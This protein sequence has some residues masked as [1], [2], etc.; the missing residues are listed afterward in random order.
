[1]YQHR[2]CLPPNAGLG[3]S[4]GDG[5]LHRL[6]RFDRLRVFALGPL[7]PSLRVSLDRGVPLLVPDGLLL[8]LLQCIAQRHHHLS[9]LALRDQLV[10]PGLQSNL[11]AVPVLLRGE[12]HMHAEHVPNHLG[13][14]FQPFFSH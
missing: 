13:N 5:D 14:R 6:H 4:L 3:A 10:G 8:D 11:G 9:R 2:H 7:R 12:D 1:M